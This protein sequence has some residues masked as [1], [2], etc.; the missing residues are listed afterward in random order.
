M[1][2]LTSEA[3]SALQSARA[4]NRKLAIALGN[5][6]LQGVTIPKHVVKKINALEEYFEGV[7]AAKKA[8]PEAEVE[9]AEAA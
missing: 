5:A 8:A 4:K 7:L 9:V 1:S 2:K 6:G 3:R